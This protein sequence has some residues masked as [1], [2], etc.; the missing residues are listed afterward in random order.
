MLKKF[1]VSKALPYLTAIIFFLVI[2]YA[3]FSPLLEGKRLSQHDYSTY[4]GGAKELK[5]YRDATGEEALWT[6]RMFVGMPS[7]LISTRYKGNLLQYVNKIVQVGPRPGSYLFLLLLGSFVLLLALKVNPWLSIAGALALA[8]SSYNFIIILAG[9]NTKVVAIAYVAPVIA[10]VIMTMRGKKFLGAAITGIFLSL[11]ILAGHP[12]ITYYTLIIL[13]IF[14]ISEVYFAIRQQQIK[15]LLISGGLLM[16]FAVFGVLSNYSR[17][18]TTMEYDDYSMRSQTELT[19]DN[20]TQTGGLSYEYA[21]GWSYGVDETFTLLIPGFKGG[22]ST[23]ELSKNS[24]TYDALAK[25]DRNF[26]ANFIKSVGLYWGSQTSTSGPVYLGAIIIFLF[27]MGLFIV[28][29][30]YKWWLL[31]ATILGILLSWGSNFE[32]LTK[33]FMNHVPGYN[34]FRTVSMTLVI[35]QITVPILA[36]LALNKVIFGNL[37][38]KE[39][40]R[41]L[42]WSTIS[43]GGLTLLFVLIPS[44]AG[45]FSSDMDMYY[46]NA[47]SNGN[48]EL[49]KVLMNSLVPALEADR[50]TMV[51]ADSFRSLVFV[52]LAAGFIYLIKIRSVKMNPNMVIGVF[53]VLFLADMWPVDKRFLND[54]NFDTQKKVDQPYTASI[55]DN[56]IIQSEGL[57]E[58]VLNLTTSPFQDGQTS[59]FHQS[60]GGYHGAKMRRYQDLINTRMMDE[61]QMLAGSLQQM[62]MSILD[63]TL[64]ELNILNMLNTKYIILDPNRAPLVNYSALG[65]AWFVNKLVFVPNADQELALTSSLNLREVAVSDRKFSGMVK[66]SVFAGNPQDRITLDDYLPNKLT[67]SSS[68]SNERLAVFSEIFYEK[69]WKATIDG[70][71]ADIIRVD[72]LLRGLVIPAGEHTIVFEFRPSSYYTG[73]KISLAGSLLLLLLFAGAV[74]LETKKGKGSVPA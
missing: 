65:N 68:S 70:Q 41:A 40:L 72:Y 47:Y 43:V 59:Y 34:K 30:R 26:A 52:A 32:G 39:I 61:I 3:Y 1:D 50:E 54:D 21:T 8:F 22:S 49:R 12:Q 9:H 38:K 35:P 23:Y 73:E 57:N 19:Q 6:N 66:D 14:G 44:L 62:N 25:L 10:G 48:P 11:E 42:K 60:L 64:N 7:Y 16:V 69:G 24:H 5:D 15:D 4:L 55:A 51:R 56:A 74:Y 17:L 31:A 67:Y 18:A 71:E 53:A 36:L 29:P 20:E 28:D 27:V 33:F 37:E 45:N 46:V 13:V 63:S 58:R 2:S